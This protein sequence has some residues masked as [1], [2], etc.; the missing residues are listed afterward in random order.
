MLRNSQHPI[1]STKPIAKNNQ[2]SIKNVEKSID[3]YSNNNRTSN[4][5]NNIYFD[6]VMIDSD[7]SE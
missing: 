2:G 6:D 1:Q 4:I 5:E 3:K 7:L